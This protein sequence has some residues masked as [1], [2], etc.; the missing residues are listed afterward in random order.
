MILTSG[1]FDQLVA[2]AGKFA[3]DDDPVTF[4][5]DPSGMLRVLV[6]GGDC[7]GVI[8]VNVV[9]DPL[10]S[11]F[12]VSFECLPKIASEIGDSS[13]VQITPFSSAKFLTNGME[14]WV[15]FREDHVEPPRVKQE[16][17]MHWDNSFSEIL[18]RVSVAC[19]DHSSNGVL[20]SVHIEQN[21]RSSSMVATDGGLI[22]AHDN[23]WRLSEEEDI[24]DLEDDPVSVLIR[25]AHV[26]I[27]Q[28]VCEAG[29]KVS[30]HI[31]ITSVL[32]KSGRRSVTLPRKGGRFPRWRN[33][34]RD[35]SKGVV[36]GYAGVFCD[37]VYT[38]VDAAQ[39]VSPTSLV[40]THGDGISL[41]SQNFSDCEVESVMNA[42]WGGSFG[43]V[44]LCSEYLRKVAIAWPEQDFKI[45][46]RGEDLPL[47]IGSVFFQSPMVAMMMPVKITEG[48]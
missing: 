43:P 7:Y 38:A 25:K 1:S 45:S 31:G 30:I 14:W 41:F 34:V 20:D 18:S 26:P 40:E 42:E 5:P 22:V 2:F 33:T 39:M 37:D 15:N 32:I 11:R 35:G 17:V 47:E 27:I 6:N 48:E 21:G 19:A 29:L 23:R 12:T 44:C 24:D 46:Y 28:K 9:S 4:S 3:S 13:Y 36:R 8:D 10:P 16:T